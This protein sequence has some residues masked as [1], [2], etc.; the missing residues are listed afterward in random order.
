[1]C[2]NTRYG[3]YIEVNIGYNNFV[4]QPC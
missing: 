3:A 2:G 1:V 4:T